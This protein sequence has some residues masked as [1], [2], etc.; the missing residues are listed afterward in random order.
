M[1]RGA[2]FSE[3]NCEKNAE[4]FYNEMKN[5]LIAHPELNWSPD[6]ASMP[7]STF[8]ALVN[9]PQFYVNG[10]PM[11]GEKKEF[12]SLSKVQEYLNNSENRKKVKAVLLRNSQG[13]EHMA[14]V[15]KVTANEI[16]YDGYNEIY[17]N[18]NGG[19]TFYNSVL[20]KDGNPK[21]GKDCNQQYYT[22][23][24]VILE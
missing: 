16:K 19:S 14:H 3:A 9:T 12:D 15:N 2:Y 1:K 17:G 11:Y 8:Y 23:I 7:I 6:S 5:Y 21:N 13:K 18:Y 20:D 10:K 24:G 22:I 4:A